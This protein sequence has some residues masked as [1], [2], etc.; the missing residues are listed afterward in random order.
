MKISNAKEI[1]LHE[2][3]EWTRIMSEENDKQ[4][5]LR[6]GMV[7]ILIAYALMLVFSLLFTMN[8]AF[9]GAFST[10][11]IITSVV[12]QFALGIASLYFI[13]A[14]L[15][16]LAPSFG[17][18]NDSMS[19]LKL[20]VFAATPSWIG[21]AL[22]RIPV[23]GWLVA[24]AGAIYAI[25]LFWQHVAEAMSIPA[26]KKVGYVIVSVVVLAV[27]FFV[28]GAIGTGIAAMVSPVSVFHVGPT[29]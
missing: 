4:S 6:Y 22:S 13:P 23:L 15:A 5:L 26:E 12:I 28:I 20:F 17:G 18:K 11:Y 21:T 9:I 3:A 10:T 1:I 7:L 2:N 16:A 19:A 25:Y 27:I 29:Y 8:V 14:I 24:L